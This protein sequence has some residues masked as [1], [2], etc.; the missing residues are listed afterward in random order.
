MPDAYKL[1]APDSVKLNPKPASLNLTSNLQR[2]RQALGA[3]AYCAVDTDTAESI[4]EA[5]HEALAR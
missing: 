2:P 3:D 1:T 5:R 4:T